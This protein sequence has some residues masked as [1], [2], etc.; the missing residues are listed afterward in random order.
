M[1]ASA[2]HTHLLAMYELLTAMAA[3]FFL[4]F[5]LA[6]F[7][8]GAGPNGNQSAPTVVVAA[9]V[10]LRLFTPWLN[11]RNVCF[12]NLLLKKEKVSL[13]LSIFS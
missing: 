2:L 3:F 6:L 8:F 9:A 5:T 1:C 11:R 13:S 10:C 4:L 7:V 12:G